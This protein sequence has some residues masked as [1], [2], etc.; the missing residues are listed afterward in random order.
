MGDVHRRF[1]STLLRGEE[2][3]RVLVV[4]VQLL[5]VPLVLTACEDYDPNAPEDNNGGYDCPDDEEFCTLDDFD[6]DEFLPFSTNEEFLTV[7]EG[8][9]HRPIFMKGVNLGVGLPGT[10]AGHLI[11]SKED[12]ERWLD[13]MSEIGVNTLRIYTLHYPRFYEALAEHNEEN[14]DDPIYVLHGVWLEE[15]FE[16]LHRLDEDFQQNIREAVDCTHGNCHIEHRYGKAYGTYQTNISEWILGW[17]IGREVGPEEVA[18]TNEYMDGENSFEG[19][20]VEANDVQPVEAWWAEQVE[21]IIDYEIDSYDQ[22]RPVSVSS[23]PTLDPMEHPSEGEEWTEEDVEEFDMMD[24]K[25]VDAP[26]GLFATY[27]AYPYYPDFI[28]NDAEYQEYEDDQ[29]PN[30]YLGYLFD[31]AE[32]HEGMPL[33]IGETGT[34]SSWGSAHWSL[35]R[36]MNHGGHTEVEQGEVASR[37]FFNA[38]ET[39]TAGAAFFAWLDEWWKPTWVTDLRDSEAER[40]PFWHNVTAPEQNFGLIAF[41]LGDPDFEE[42]ESHDGSGLVDRATVTHDAAYF[43]VRLDLSSSFGSG[44]ELTVAF[45]TY[46]DEESTQFDEELGE[47]ELPNGVKTDNRNEFAL[48][49]EGTERADLKVTESYDTYR[50]WHGEA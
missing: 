23:W 20:R 35:E 41:D 22:T 28:I 17:I 45:D 50:I 3:R 26:G 29:G 8:G 43:H 36:D 46:G 27:H 39:N 18:L 49:I 14:E 15:E 13:R 10:R 25:E 19:E 21:F 40:R 12:Y 33:F 32:H 7:K 6:E 42:G 47:S 37:L 11:A 44:D 34:S 16:G 31:L 48:E 9:D 30:S 24:I 1:A 38:Y 5:V 4:A 2:L